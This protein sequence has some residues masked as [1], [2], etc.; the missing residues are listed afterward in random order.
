MNPQYTPLPNNLTAVWFAIFS[1]QKAFAE[2]AFDQLTEEQFFTAPTP[3]LNSCVL[4]A[5]PSS[6]DNAHTL[7]L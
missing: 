3:G 2:H 5:S 6:S 4:L 7:P 1:R